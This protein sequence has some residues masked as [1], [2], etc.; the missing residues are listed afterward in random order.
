MTEHIDG[1]DDEAASVFDHRVGRKDFLFDSAK[2][3]AAAAAPV[4]GPL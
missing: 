3:L 2:L 1:L 4:R